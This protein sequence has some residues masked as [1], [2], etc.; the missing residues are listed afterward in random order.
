M[1]FG[2]RLRRSYHAARE[3][4]TD[5]P[6]PVPFGSAC[7]KCEV[8]PARAMTYNAA[9]TC[10]GVRWRGVLAALEVGLLLPRCLSIQWRQFD[11]RAM[12]LFLAATSVITVSAE[13][14]PR[15]AKL[16]KLYEGGH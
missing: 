4:R 16:E 13:I 12:I 1:S 11:M 5:A 14:F 15:G 6:V 7:S 10:L 2:S 8:L 9:A 3:R